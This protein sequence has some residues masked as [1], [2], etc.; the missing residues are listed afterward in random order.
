MIAL[1]LRSYWRESI[2]TQ[3]ECFAGLLQRNAAYLSRMLFFFTVIAA[4]HG[5]VETLK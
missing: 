4:T 3:F 2:Y 5:F 1:S